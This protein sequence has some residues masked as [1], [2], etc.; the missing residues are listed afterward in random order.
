MTLHHQTME[1]MTIDRRFRSIF[2]AGPSF[3]LLPDDR[4]T[5]GALERIHQHLEPGGSA[6][7][8]LFI[9]TPTP[10]RELGRARARRGGRPPAPSDDGLRIADDTARCQRAVLRYEIIDGEA[11]EVVERDWLLHWH[12]QDGFRDLCAAADLAIT[13]VHR[14]DGKPA[15]PRDDAFVFR[16]AR[17]LP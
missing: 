8:P 4:T 6:L 11:T 5:A 16:L 14:P 15:G 1:S 9:P 2:V 12:T 13:R 7:I 3:N 17:S 10:H